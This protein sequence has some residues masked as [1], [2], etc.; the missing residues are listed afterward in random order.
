MAH[1][2]R[3]V[4]IEHQVIEQRF[5]HGTC[6]AV[7]TRR[8]HCQ[9]CSPTIPCNS[10]RHVGKEPGSG[11]EAVEAFGMELQLSQ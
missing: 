11:L 2:G 7:G 10:R 9:H 6:D 8:A 4:H 1:S 3:Q 5:H